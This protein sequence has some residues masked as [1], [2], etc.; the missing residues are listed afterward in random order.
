M[1]RDHNNEQAGARTDRMFR[2]EGSWFFRTREGG[3]AGPFRDELEA[4]TQLEV[5][6]RLADSGLLTA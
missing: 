1:T 3:I 6:I 4:I 5:Y 2:E